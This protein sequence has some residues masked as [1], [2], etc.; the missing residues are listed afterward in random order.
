M[1]TAIAESADQPLAKI[2]PG[3]CGCMCAGCDQM[4]MHCMKAAKGC[5][6]KR[7]P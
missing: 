2:V 6:W 7:V 1:T 4:G 5:D 3:P